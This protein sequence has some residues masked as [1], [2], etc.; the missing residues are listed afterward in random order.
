VDE[1]RKL[2]EQWRHVKGV[3][4]V[5]GGY[6]TGRHLDNA[7]RKVVYQKKEARKT[8]LDYVRVIDEELEL[9]RKEFGLE[10]DIQSVLK[11]SE[12]GTLKTGK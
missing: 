10:T 1:L 4:E 9:K 6:M 12:E 8:L 5:P 7:F 2:N 3:P 11:A